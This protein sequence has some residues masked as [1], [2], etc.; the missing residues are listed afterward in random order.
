MAWNYEFV[1][2]NTGT[3]SLYTL[4]LVK[5]QITRCTKTQ[6]SGALA[7]RF[8]QVVSFF[9][10]RLAQ[11][12]SI[13]IYVSSLQRICFAIGIFPYNQNMTM[14]HL[15]SLYICCFIEISIFIYKELMAYYEQSNLSREQ[16]K[17]QIQERKIVFLSLFIRGRQNLVC[18]I[19][20]VLIASIC[21]ILTPNGL[22]AHKVITHLIKRIYADNVLY[23]HFHGRT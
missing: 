15:T 3:I 16:K 8:R 10:R 21:P 20:T 11:Q 9:M 18:Q 4:N 6:S 1:V 22:Y 5:T 7:K 12:I 19:Q 2:D 13:P 23:M 17:S 14:Y